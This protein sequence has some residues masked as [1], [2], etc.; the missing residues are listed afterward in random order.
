[1]SHRNVWIRRVSSG[2]ASNI[3]SR[4]GAMSLR[5][6]NT[7]RHVPFAVLLEM[8]MTYRIVSS[9]Q[10]D[11]ISAPTDGNCR[12]QSSD[13]SRKDLKFLVANSVSCRPWG[14]HKNHDSNSTFCKP[15]LHFIV[16]LLFNVRGRM[17]H[18]CH[19]VDQVT[20]HGPGFGFM[21]LRP[22]NLVAALPDKKQNLD[23]EW[24][25]TSLL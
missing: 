15:S 13:F 11:F 7:C 5:E 12:W 8:L 23:V 25:V 10:G 18:I 20:A 24:T 14:L 3:H 6:R 17:S 4:L 21:S 22:S 9:G 19:I 16:Y 2:N 1:M